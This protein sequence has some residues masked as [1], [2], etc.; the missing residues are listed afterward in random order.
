MPQI[1]M[2]SSTLLDMGGSTPAPAH[3]YSEM[4][5]DYKQPQKGKGLVGNT[6]VVKT[7]QYVLQDNGPFSIGLQKLGMSYSLLNHYH[8]PG[9]WK[10]T[11]G[12]ALHRKSFQVH[13]KW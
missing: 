5:V 12:D 13:S 4:S 6:N 3:L 7:I 10:R 11:T 9:A 2:F 1:F 8:R